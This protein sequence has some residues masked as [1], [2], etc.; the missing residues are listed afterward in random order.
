MFDKVELL[1][2]GD[3]GDRISEDRALVYLFGL[4]GLLVD[5]EY[6]ESV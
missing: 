6:D 3:V 1:D 4:V 2:F 5:F